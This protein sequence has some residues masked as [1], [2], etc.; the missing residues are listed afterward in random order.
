MAIIHRLTV[1]LQ[2]V[3]IEDFS[4][5]AELIA[6]EAVAAEKKKSRFSSACLLFWRETS[7]LFTLMRKHIKIVVNHKYF[8]QGKH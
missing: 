5:C 8:Q 6:A 2:I 3:E 7:K 4:C 1:L